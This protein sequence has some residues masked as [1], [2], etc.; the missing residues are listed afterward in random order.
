MVIPALHIS[1]VLPGSRGV[2]YW[3]C[4]HHHDADTTS[5]THSSDLTAPST[6]TGGRCRFS[7]VDIT[8]IVRQIVGSV[9]TSL[10]PYPLSIKNPIH[11][12]TRTNTSNMSNLTPQ[13]MEQ[14]L[15][16]TMIHERDAQISS[17]LHQL[18]TL[19]DNI[20]TLQKDMHHKSQQRKHQRDEHLASIQKLKEEHTHQRKL[21]ARYENKRETEKCDINKFFC[22]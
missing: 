20:T 17:L 22:L 16:H 8:L 10:T 19:S 13:S 14:S 15:L 2:Y 5:N 7:K 6:T 12:I 11:F 4:G 9:P 21:L 18:H 3:I 1:H